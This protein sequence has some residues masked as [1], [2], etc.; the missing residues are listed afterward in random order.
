[1]VSTLGLILVIVIVA[2]VIYVFPGIPEMFKRILYV[3]VGIIFILWLL[4]LL[5]VTVPHGR[6]S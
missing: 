4:A 1:M 6:L 2:A 5:G 3:I